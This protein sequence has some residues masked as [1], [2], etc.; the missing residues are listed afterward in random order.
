MY[1]V[2]L[3]DKLGETIYDVWEYDTNMVDVTHGEHY[4][5]IGMK[6]A[7]LNILARIENGQ[8]VDVEE[9]F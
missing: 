9:V 8:R 1:K 6:E 3:H 4:T 2:T 7:L 5:H